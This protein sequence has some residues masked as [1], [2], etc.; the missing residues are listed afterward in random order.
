MSKQTFM[1]VGASLAG[2]KAAEELR[3]RGFDGRVVLI[4]SEP[5][6]PYERPPLTKDYLRG[7]S[8]REKAYV[9]AAGLLRRARDRADDRHDGD[10]DRPRR[11]RGSRSP[12][13]ASSPTTGCCWRPAPSRGG[14]RFPAPSSTGSTTC[15]RSPTATCCAR[16]STRGGR[17]VVVGAGWI[18][19]EFAASARQRGLEV[20]VIDPLRAAQR[21]HLRRRDRRLLP[22]RAPPARRRAAARRGGRGVRGRR[23]GR[24]RAHR[25]AAARSSATSPSSAS[26][27]RRASSSARAPAWR[28]TTA[29]SSTSGSQ[30]IGAGRL[31]GRRRRQRA[32]SVLRAARSASSTGPTRSTRARRRR[33]RCS[34]SRSATTASRTSSPTSTTSAW[35]TRATRPSWDEVVFRGDRDGG[36]FIAFWLRDGAWSP[37]MNVNVWDVNEHVQALIRSRQASTSPR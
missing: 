32:A 1:I 35:S 15:A 34:A 29:S 13:G 11:A 26:A 33:A 12:T 20:T 24:A 22:R 8:E 19:S 10:R 9:H 4:G 31:R 14:S 2:A 25:S 3:E 27:S 6:R 18:G 30:T 23:R 5:E 17:V 28:S 37:G 7:E 36:E 16:G 21:A